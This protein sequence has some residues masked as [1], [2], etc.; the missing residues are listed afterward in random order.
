MTN[1]VQKLA[2][3]FGLYND[4]NGIITVEMVNTVN[5]ERMEYVDVYQVF[6]QN[7]LDDFKFITKYNLL[8]NTEDY[9]Y[10][11]VVDLPNGYPINKSTILNGEI[12]TISMRAMHRILLS[13]IRLGGKMHFVKD[14]FLKWKLLDYDNQH[15]CLLKKAYERKPI[16]PFAV[17]ETS[18]KKI[19]FIV[20]MEP[21]PLNKY[22][23][24]KYMSLYTMK[25]SDIGNIPLKYGIKHYYIKPEA[26]ETL[27][28]YSR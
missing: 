12:L 11:P 27:R 8:D 18:N 1:V 9:L 28:F 4:P 6:N 22:T 16:E 19:L 14:K 26:L 23:N 25:E 10:I 7:E 21:V 20:Y 2:K 3:E 24:R 17:A 5:S 15:G 13:E